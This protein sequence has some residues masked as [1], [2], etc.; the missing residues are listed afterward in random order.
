MFRKSCY[1]FVT[2][3][4][5]VYHYTRN[6]LPIKGAEHMC[7]KKPIPIR[8]AI[9]KKHGYCFKCWNGTHRADS[10]TVKIICKRCR[11]D[12]PTL[13][14]LDRP[15]SDPGQAEQTKGTPRASN[16]NNQQ[17][18]RTSAQQGAPTLSQR[19]N[20]Q[21]SPQQGGAKE[22]SQK[23]SVKSPKCTQLCGMNASKSFAKIFLC[24]W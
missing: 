22:S 13:L 23:D 19:G 5:M 6:R 16:Q 20:L 2:I 8:R 3:P 10:C 14:H 11:S 1:S 4:E 9:L 12:H 21:S 15:S 24:G 17:D 18:T 7:L